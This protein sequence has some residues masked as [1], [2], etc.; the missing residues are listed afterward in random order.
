MIE[1]GRPEDALIT[2][3]NLGV[4]LRLL[5]PGG[6]PFLISLLEGKTLGEAAAAGAEDADLFDLAANIRGML[7][8]GVFAKIVAMRSENANKE[9]QIVCR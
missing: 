2:R 1:S 7:E 3:P 6:A 8:S 4:E 5:P 9:L